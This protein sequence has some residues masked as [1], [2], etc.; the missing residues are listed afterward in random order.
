MKKKIFGFC[1]VFLFLSAVAGFSQLKAT[2]SSRYSCYNMTVRGRDITYTVDYAMVSQYNDGSFQLV[3][4][5][6]DATPTEYFRLD[7]PTRSA[8]GTT[9]N[10]RLTNDAGIR[11]GNLT[12]FITAGET[13]LSFYFYQNGENFADI[14]LR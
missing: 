12:C 4:Y 2:D 1:L 11:V 13:L 6:K 9:Y 14:H 8:N 10:A 5:Y 3:L 7:A